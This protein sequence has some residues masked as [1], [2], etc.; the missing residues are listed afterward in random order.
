MR[1]T[2]RKWRFFGLPVG[3]G[4]YRTTAYRTGATRCMALEKTMESP[5]RETLPTV[6]K[7]D[8]DLLKGLFDRSWQSFDERR[9]HEY[10][11]SYLVWAAYVLFIA[12]AHGLFSKEGK[13]PTIGQQGVYITGGALCL[14]ALAHFIWIHGI[15]RT[16]HRDKRIADFYGT[17]I[18]NTLNIEEAFRSKLPNE[19]MT[20]WNSS[21]RWCVANWNHLAE[22]MVTAAMLL[23]AL[24]ALYR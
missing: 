2:R 5:Q 14:V 20:R 3:L 10:H 17:I 12:A 23:A 24:S 9:R 22:M 6:E 19:K 15:A 1:I 7:S 11:L 8:L 21:R 16:Q 4:P 18:R 13:A